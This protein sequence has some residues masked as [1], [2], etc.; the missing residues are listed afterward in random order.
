MSYS[1]TD[2]IVIYL[3]SQGID[4]ARVEKSMIIIPLPGGET[5]ERP[6]QAVVTTEKLDQLIKDYKE[7]I[8]GQENSAGLDG[9]RTEAGL[10]ANVRQRHGWEKRLLKTNRASRDFPLVT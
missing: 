2:K 7:H 9:A 3:Q 6:I 8:N 1:L 5:F 4:G 10:Q